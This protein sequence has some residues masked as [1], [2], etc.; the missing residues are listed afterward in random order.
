[1]NIPNKLTLLRILIIPVMLGIYYLDDAPNTLNTMSLVLAGLFILASFT[2]FLDGYLARK[3]DL[4]TTFGKFLDPLA[5]KLL[6]MF[7]LLMLLDLGTIPMWV[8]LLI[9]TREFVVTGIRLVAMGE[10]TVIAASPLGKY[11]TAVTMLGIIILLFHYITIGLIVFYVGVILTVISGIEY[12]W[13][14]RTA[15]L[16]SK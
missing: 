3:H 8:V 13:K 7:A 14:N 4:V 16:S 12:F 10:G 2:D 9:L 1:M 11:K 5:D 15:L 6:V